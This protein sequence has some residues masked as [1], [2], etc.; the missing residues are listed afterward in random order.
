M[1][2]VIYK[3]EKSGKSQYRGSARK[4]LCAA[5]YVAAKSSELLRPLIVAR[6]TI[7]E[8]AGSGRI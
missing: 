2:F 1:F 3:Y 7:P 5:M 8:G 4:A 6:D